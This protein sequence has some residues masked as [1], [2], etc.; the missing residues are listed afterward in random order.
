MADHNS[1][2]GSQISSSQDGSAPE[3]VVVPPT[4]HVRHT[5]EEENAM[6]HRTQRM[7][8]FLGGP[9]R[10]IMSV[11]EALE[12]PAK[13]TRADVGIADYLKLTPEEAVQ[14]CVVN[15]KL[16][17]LRERSRSRLHAEQSISGLRA[18]DT[19]PDEQKQA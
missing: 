16:R 13:L 9:K 5:P 3:S 4:N 15:A 1:G 14:W 10:R 17:A 2:T 6:W 11:E 7:L 12:A 19:S 18:S 8:R